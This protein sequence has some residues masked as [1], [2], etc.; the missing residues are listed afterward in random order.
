MRTADARSLSQAALDQWRA[1]LLR[2]RDRDASALE[3]LYRSSSPLLLGVIRAIV[4]DAEAADEALLDVY[5]QVW[6]QAHTFDPA[7]G[8]AAAFLF[9]LARTRALDRRRSLCAE[10]RREVDV[11]AAFVL[12]AAE[13]G[14]N[15]SA[16]LGEIQEQVRGAVRRLPEEQREL[17]ELAWFKGLSHLQIVERVRQPLGTVKTRI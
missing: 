1:L 10:R 12:A 7:R 9:L 6:R 5:E 13:P 3:D 11:E 17:I 15:D 2:V 14:P 16:A 8:S 4:G